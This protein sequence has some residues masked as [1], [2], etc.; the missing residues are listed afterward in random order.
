MLKSMNS[1]IK[2]F[3]L[4][5]LAPSSCKPIPSEITDQNSGVMS[6]YASQALTYDFPEL[7]FQPISYDD[8]YPDRCKGGLAGLRQL[9]AQKAGGETTSYALSGSSHCG[10]FMSEYCDGMNHDLAK[11]E[12]PSTSPKVGRPS[13]DIDRPAPKSTRPSVGFKDS[14]KQDKRDDVS[15]HLKEFEPIFKKAMAAGVPGRALALMSIWYSKNKRKLPND[16]YV[17][18]VDYSKLKTEK[19]LYVLDLK[20][21]IVLSYETA[22][23]KNS[24]AKERKNGE[25][26][27]RTVSF[28]DNPGDNESVLGF[29][30]TGRTYKGKYGLS[31]VLHGLEP[32]KNA[33]SCGR[34]LVLHQ[35]KPGAMANTEGC[36][37]INVEHA[38]EVIA[39]IKGGSAMLLYHP[40][41]M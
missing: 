37:T 20:T 13:S 25:P 19:R 32:G 15:G 36:L 7:T 35:W 6:S 30:I 17:T 8:A 22:H 9:Y 31:L 4:I 10:P 23:G 21:N 27:F 40:D 34:L 14:G 33:S 39:K 38:E 1:S 18:I 3:L 5:T 29:L 28:S 2:I 12:Q 41:H 24:E 26:V 16:R 11:D